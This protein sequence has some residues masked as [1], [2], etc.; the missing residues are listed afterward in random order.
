MDSQFSILVLWNLCL[1]SVGSQNFEILVEDFDIGGP[2]SIIVSY[3]RIRI[4]FSNL[5]LWTLLCDKTDEGEAESI[6]CILV[7]SSF[8]S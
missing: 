3:E 8:P 1:E 2:N 6:I 7:F 5:I 4:F